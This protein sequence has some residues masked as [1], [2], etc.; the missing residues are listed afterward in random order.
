VE[1]LQEQRSIDNGK[2]VSLDTDRLVELTWS[3]PPADP[4]IEASFK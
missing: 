3:H 4:N 2:F 1:S